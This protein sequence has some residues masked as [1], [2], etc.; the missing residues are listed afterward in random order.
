MSTTGT[1]LPAIVAVPSNADPQLKKTLDSLIEVVQVLIGRRGDPRDRA[2]TLRELVKSGLAEELLDNPFSITSGTGFVDFGP[3]SALNDV[4]I[5]PAPTG[6]AASAAFTTTVVSWDDPQFGNFA[7]AEVFRATSNNISNAVL[8]DTTTASIWSDS[9]DYNQTFYYWV[10]F[11]STSDI[12]GPFAG[13]VNATTAANITAVM[14]SLSQTLAD[15]PGYN[16][17]AT[18]T[19]AA[20]II[21]SSSQPS[22]RGDGS[23]IQ[24]NDIWFDTDDGQIYT[25]N[26]ANNAWVAGRDATLVTL[27]GSTSFTG[28]TLTGALAT[29][30]SDIVTVT[31]SQSATASS[32]TSLTSTVG[33]NTSSIS[34]LNTTTASHTGD[35]NAMF[36]LQV[37]T[38]SDGSKSAAGMVVGSNAS[39]GSGAQSYVQFQADKFVVWNGNNAS[40]APFIV[41]SNTVFIK[42]A[43]IQDAAITSAKIASLAV[44]EARIANAAVTNAKLGDASISTA[45]IQDA[46]IT[47]AKILNAA[48]TNA[49]IATAA[50]DTAKVSSLFANTLNGDVSK[51][52]A[53]KLAS[54]VSFTNNSNTFVTVLENELA[55]P[56]H[57]TGWVPYASFNLNRVSVEK[58]SYYHIVI[59]M[60][61]W[62]V[63]SQGGT[64]S[65]AASTSSA[66]SA[67]GSG[68]DGS[69][70]TS[71]FITGITGS[72]VANVITVAETV[73][74]EVVSGDI[75]F[76][77]SEERTVTGNAVVSGSRVIGYSGSSFG[78]S[79]SYTFGF[80]ESVTSGNVG[81]YV[82]VSKILWV[83]VD[84]AFND[85]AIAGVFGGGTASTVTH[86]VKARVRISG[87]ANVIGSSNAATTENVHDATGILIGVR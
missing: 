86:G 67:F 16:L 55:K 31:N 15:L 64:S 46:A 50:I 72:H 8:A 1:K 26:A 13:S 71:T 79:S 39:D 34:T 52:T 61:A 77:G 70:I 20:T 2:V 51:A 36:V 40:T 76:V 69:A 21:K 49:K 23:S 43:M 54:S 19:T 17:L 82:E 24:T 65:E 48:V 62:N 56:T 7:F 12:R 32:L 47:D 59:E 29:A 42:D 73:A 28:S 68:Y 58:N 14:T 84:T 9:N 10:R 41:S 57:S 38:E 66:P 30:Q 81:K 6:L 18:S 35:L 78:S 83:A 27:V 44:D 45:K 5:P 22:T 60:A 75:V 74:T 63:N 33:T 53:T 4:T 25:R 85:F 87:D 3:P 80:K 11:V 37:S